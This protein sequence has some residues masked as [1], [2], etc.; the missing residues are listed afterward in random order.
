MSRRPL[1]YAYL[2]SERKNQKGDKTEKGEKSYWNKIGAA[3]PHKDSKG[4]DVVLDGGGKIVLRMRMEERE[5]Q[6]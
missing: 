1:F 2:V 6:A 4:H 3:F 5:I